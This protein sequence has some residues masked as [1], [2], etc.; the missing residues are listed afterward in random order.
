[1]IANYHTHTWRCNHA[2]A[3]ENAYVQSALKRGLTTLGFSDHTPYLFPNGYYSTFRMR[4]EQLTD[5]T[6]CIENLQKKYDGQIQIHIGLEAEYYPLPFPELRAILRDSQVTYLLLGQHFNGN[7]IGEHY[8]A[9]PTA[10]DGIL[11]T[12]CRQIMDGI[13]TGCFS[14]VAHPDLINYQGSSR[15]YAEQM[16]QLCREAKLCGIPLEFN[17]L[18]LAAGRAYPH[19]PFWQIAAEEGNTVVLGCDAHTADSLSDVKTEQ[20][21]LSILAPL[22]IVPQETVDLLPIL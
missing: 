6:Q 8:N 2:D 16:R 20:K 3:D 22:G 13:H 4:M 14:Y 9:A 19:L 15:L 17:L 18:G 11:K 10:D 12:Y 7:E 1:M 21:A 5:Y